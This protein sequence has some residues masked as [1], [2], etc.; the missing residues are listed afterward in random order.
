MLNIN[1]VLPV[2][3][4]ISVLLFLI[5]SS[6]YAEIVETTDGRKIKLNDDGTYKI[7][8][9][10]NSNENQNNTV[11]SK[12]LN[13]HLF[14]KKN[15]GGGCEAFFEATNS[16]EYNFTWMSF[17]WIAYDSDNYIIQKF[18]FNFERL[19]PE[20]EVIESL[21]VRDARCSEVSKI[22]LQLVDAKVD[23]N[24]LSDSDMSILE[25]DYIS[26]SSSLDDTEAILN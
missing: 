23:G 8:V 22:K 15:Y 9:K 7:I 4:F 17:D 12:P 5:C 11:E 3:Y 1:G 10:D 25:K 20:S 6:L 21:W 13:F 26:V 16:F 18:L 14:Q 24:F 19:K 2:K